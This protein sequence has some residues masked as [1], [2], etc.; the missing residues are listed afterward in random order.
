MKTDTAKKPRGKGKHGAGGRKRANGTGTLE[1]RGNKWRGKWLVYDPQGNKVWKTQTLQATNL[2]DA[3][4]ELKELTQGNAIMSRE[5][6]LER[7]QRELDGARAERKAWEDGLPALPIADA[8]TA[9]ETN[10]NRPDTGARTLADYEGYFAALAKWMQT[11]YPNATE[12]R[13]I[14]RTEAEAYAADLRATRSAGTFN[15]RITFFRHF[16][17]TLADDAGK[18]PQAKDLARLPA[19]LIINPWEKIQKRQL[20]THTR[21]ELTVEELGRVLQ[22]LQGE[23]RVLFALGI[24]TGARLGDCALMEW[25]MIDLA[26]GR[27]AFTP[28]KTKRHANGKQAIIPL[29]PILAGILSETP[30]EERTGYVMPETAAAYEREASILT[31]RIQKHFR[32]CGIQ[33]ATAQGEG[34]RAI[35]EVGFHSLR[36][37]FVSLSANAGTP[38]AIVQAI[39]GHSNPAMTRHYFHESENALRGAVAALPDVITIDAEATDA[40]E[41][42]G[43]A[44]EGADGAEAATTPPDAE[45]APTGVLARFAAMLA[46]MTA[47]ERREAARILADYQ[48]N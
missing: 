29:H 9:Y 34:R 31:N 36:H 13:Q 48:N 2:D 7:T 39:V 35:T 6:M 15:K 42:N 40:P 24:Y 19:K 5:K 32:A 21:R 1:K 41:R 47:E 12:L 37:T 16:W 38:L 26:R 4:A 28:R 22:G 43:K 33:T 10:A 46:E 20:D 44:L 45:N 30:P 27:I 8:W 23:M 17:K 11:H 3:R 25:G 18:D 14:T